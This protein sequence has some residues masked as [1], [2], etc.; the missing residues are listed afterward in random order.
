MGGIRPIYIWLAY[1]TAKLVSSWHFKI[2]NNEYRWDTKYG[3]NCQ[4]LMNQ[5]PTEMMVYCK[6]LATWD[7]PHPKG[8][9]TF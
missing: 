9:R 5:I 8:Y 6:R 4:D 3:M 2:D 7:Y 1:T